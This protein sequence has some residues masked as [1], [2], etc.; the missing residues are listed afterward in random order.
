MALTKEAVLRLKTE[1]FDSAEKSARI[2]AARMDAAT[3]SAA[4]MSEIMRSAGA[5]ALP[6]IQRASGATPQFRLGET[7]KSGGGAHGWEGATKKLEEAFKEV[8]KAARAAAV[9]LKIIAERDPAPAT[10]TAS[11]AKTDG[12]PRG[13]ITLGHVA[14]ATAALTGAFYAANAAGEA[15]F[16]TIGRGETV[17]ALASS[18]EQLS[19][20]I[21]GASST[22]DAL[23]A[24]TSGVVDDQTLMLA[25]NKLMIADIGLSQA[26]VAGLTGAAV[27]LSKAM[28]TTATSAV[29]DLAE[30]LQKQSPMILDNLGLTVKMEAVVKQYAAAHGIAAS[31]IDDQTRKLL[32]AKVAMEGAEEAGKKLGASGLA[33]VSATQ[34]MTTAWTN[35]G[36]QVDRLVAEQPGFAEA[37][38][39]TAEAAIDIGKAL[40]PLIQVAGQLARELAP[41]IKM[42]GEAAAFIA[43]SGALASNVGALVSS[44]VPGGA[45]F[46]APLA[47]VGGAQSYAA[48]RGYQ[49]VNGKAS[50]VHVHLTAGATQEALAKTNDA[51]RRAEA[52]SAGAS[53]FGG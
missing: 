33:S 31:E 45:V 26:Q 29:R 30:G 37:L 1:G 18:F 48:S 13:A 20:P 51:L 8:D 40:T 35:F 50:D 36:T 16:E 11:G 38:K 17:A 3:K 39:A 27:T 24:A 43:G 46:G 52:N 6:G 14:A 12:A 10:A 32:F 7:A 19:T 41:V 21:G 25:T 2:I 23:R 53:G 9:A 49:G 15:L 22:L 28:G 44:A 47:L 5:G 34:Q 4:V 42:L